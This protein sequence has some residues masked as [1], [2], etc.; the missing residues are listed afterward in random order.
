MTGAWWET[1]LRTGEWEGMVD[2][3][4]DMGPPTATG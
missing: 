2:E 1:A 4:D 3:E